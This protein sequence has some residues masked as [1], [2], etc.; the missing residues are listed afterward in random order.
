[1]STDH[2]ERLAARPA[3]EAVLRVGVGL[4]LA[5]VA[6]ALTFYNPNWFAAAT[7]LVGLLAGREWHRLVRRPE[8]RED[9][10]A[11]PL[12]LQTILTGAAIGL[13]MA[14]LLLGQA[15]AACGVLAAGA[16]ASLLLALSDEDNPLWHGIGVLYV[17]APCLALVAL[18]SRASHGSTVVLGL[19]LIIWA[20]DT[21][22]LVFGK[23]IGGAKLAPAIS[24]AKTWAGTIGGSFT[25]ALVYALYIAVLGFH[26]AAGFVF[27][28]AFSIVAHAGDLLESRVKRHFGAKDSGGLL[29]GHGG[30]LDRIDSM[31]AAAP[32]MALLVFGLHFNP[33]F[34]GLS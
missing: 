13:A 4:F 32:V 30:I 3:S 15:L 34:G 12:H 24:P 17:G 21:G 8:L 9:A 22:A 14:A 10:E 7:A 26:V 2:P 31:L 33:L 18:Q 28:L 19:F 29:P 5:V 16:L 11:K 23:L 6:V 27:A 25:G 1:V 20:T